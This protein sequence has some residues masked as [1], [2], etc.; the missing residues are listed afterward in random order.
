MSTATRTYQKFEG[1]KMIFGK[2]KELH[3]VGIGGAGMSG[4][5]EILH[6]LGYKITGS[7]I[8]PG[9]VTEHLE[10][11][12][13]TVFRGHESGHIGT[14]NVVVISSAVGPDN[15]ELVEAE[16]RG[17]PVI[18]RAEML[19]ELMR[20]KYSVGIAGTHGKTTT[21]SMI[22]N[23]LSDAGLDPTVIVGGVVAGKG[24]GASLGA[25]EYLVAEADE[26]DRSF[27]SMFPSLAVITN[28]EPDHLDCYED[29]TDL[30][31]CFLEYMNRTPFYGEVVYSADDT[32]LAKIQS[33]IKR[34]SVTFGFSENADYRAVDFKLTEG[35]S[36]FTVLKHGTNLGNIILHVPGRYNAR[37]AMAAVATAMEL[38]TPFEKIADSLLDFRGVTRRFEVKGIIDN[39]MVVDDYA[40][41]PTEIIATLRAAKDSYNRRVI[42]VFQPHLFSRTR[43]FYREFT[44]ALNI[45]DLVFLVDIFPAREEPV[46]GVTS[47]MISRYAVKKGYNH[48]H[49]IGPKENAVDE[50]LK[51]AKPGD[52]VITIGAG[53]IYRINPEIIRGLENR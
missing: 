11:L 12:G 1:E 33:R 32:V 43:Q 18:K 22:G 51:T 36:V 25:G 53:S 34:A 47:E 30:E 37:N 46:E 15:P 19:G 13:I 4:I 24:S 42:A 31:N 48:I 39:I 8:R 23:I 2:F 6:N 45:A 20:L 10:R 14:A 17:I 35:G 40:H 27:L 7:D 9:E 21:T 52:M 16:R 26:Y 28:I 29:M 5:A 49:Y 50:V 3:F 38:D 41:H 44:E